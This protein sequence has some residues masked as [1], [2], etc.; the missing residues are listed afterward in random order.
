[1]NLY[2]LQ[3]EPIIYLRNS[4]ILDSKKEVIK[5]WHR[6]RILFNEYVQPIWLQYVLEIGMLIRVHK[7]G[8]IY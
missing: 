7:Y 5:F 2:K 3:N 4:Y 1:M 6:R 8:L